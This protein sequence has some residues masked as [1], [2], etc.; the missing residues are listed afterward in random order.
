MGIEHY[1]WYIATVEMPKM[2]IIYVRKTLSAEEAALIPR[3]WNGKPAH[4]QISARAQLL[5]H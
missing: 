2:V 3:E 4:Y 1:P 5:G